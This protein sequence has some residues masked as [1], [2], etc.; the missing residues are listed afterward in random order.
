[1]ATR[2]RKTPATKKIQAGNAKQGQ[3]KISKS[4]TPKDKEEINSISF[5]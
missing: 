4:D 1:M 5:S 3:N 2:N